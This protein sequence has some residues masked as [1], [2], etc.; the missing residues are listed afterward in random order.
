[1]LEVLSY[2]YTCKQL[3]INIYFARHFSTTEIKK[4][5]DQSETENFLHIFQKLRLK[6]IQRF[7]NTTKQDF[8]NS[9]ENAD[10]FRKMR[11]VVILTEK[12]E[13]RKQ[14]PKKCKFFSEY[15]FGRKCAFLHEENITKNQDVLEDMIFFKSQIGNS[16]EHFEISCIHKTRR[17]SV[18]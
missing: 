7:V 15:K 5:D 13:C 10:T 4:Q 2:V 12:N 9:E 11:G 1:M 16:Q 6:W 18:E 14:I 8:A 3:K 17:L